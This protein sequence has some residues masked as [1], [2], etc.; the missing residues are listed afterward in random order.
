VLLPK[1]VNGST[2]FQFLIGKI[3]PKVNWDVWTPRAMFQFLIGKINPIIGLVN[4][5]IGALNKIQI[6][7]PDWVPEYGGQKWGIDIEPIKE[8]DKEK[9]MLTAD[10]VREAEKKEV[11]VSGKVTFEGVNSE[12]DVVAAVD[13]IWDQLMDRFALEVRR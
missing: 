6:E 4:K 1:G 10:Q 5:I 8:L 9:D 12:G 3:N 13:A 11:E 7:I 2:G